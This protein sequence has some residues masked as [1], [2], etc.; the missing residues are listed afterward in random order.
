MPSP[1]TRYKAQ[2]EVEM[3][4]RAMRE[5]ED[6]APST[7]HLLTRRS[8]LRREAQEKLDG[9]GTRYGR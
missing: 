6:A 8:R 1:D 2:W 9:R 7:E 3:E 5:R 4:L